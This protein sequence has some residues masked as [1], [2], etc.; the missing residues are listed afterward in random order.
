M[1]YVLEF[2]IFLLLAFAF[3]GI[4]NLVILWLIYRWYVRN[5]KDDDD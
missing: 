4:G 5:Q 3:P 1:D 2:I